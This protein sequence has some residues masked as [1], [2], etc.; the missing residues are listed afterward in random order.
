MEINKEILNSLKR[1]DLIKYK[2]RDFKTI[3]L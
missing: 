2:K 3:S 1:G